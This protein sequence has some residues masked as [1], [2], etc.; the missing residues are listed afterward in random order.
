MRRGRWL[1]SGPAIFFS[2]ATLRSD[3]QRGLL[4]TELLHLAKPALD[5]AVAPLLERLNKTAT[6]FPGT[7]PQLGYSLDPAALPPG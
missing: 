2:P 3:A 5:R 4:R 7:A 1:A 6:R